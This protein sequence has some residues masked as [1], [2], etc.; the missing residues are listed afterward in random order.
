MSLVSCMHQICTHHFCLDSR[1][2][3]FAWVTFSQFLQLIQAIFGFQGS[4]W[5]SPALWNPPIILLIFLSWQCPFYAFPVKTH[6]WMM[7]QHRLSYVVIC[8]ISVFFFFNVNV[9]HPLD[10]LLSLWGQDSVIYNC[11]FLLAPKQMV[12]PQKIPIECFAD[13]L[14]DCKRNTNLYLWFSVMII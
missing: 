8:C 2:P 9:F 11:V 4:E 14:I 3:S 6:E 5:S 1:W 7:I 13:Y 12:K 10:Q